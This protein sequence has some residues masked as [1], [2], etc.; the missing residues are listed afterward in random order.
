MTSNGLFIVP[1]PQAGRGAHST[2]RNACLFIIVIVEKK[3]TLSVIFFSTVIGTVIGIHC[4][5]L[6]QDKVKVGK[7]D[8]NF[9]DEQGVGNNL[10]G[11]RLPRPTTV[12]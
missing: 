6:Y 3:I 2:E 12:D 10:A 8:G 7:S 1:L 4:I 11:G 9:R 5:T